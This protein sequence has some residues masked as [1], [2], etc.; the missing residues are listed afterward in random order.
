MKF[1]Q[2]LPGI[3]WSVQ[4]CRKNMHYVTLFMR[5]DAFAWLSTCPTFRDL[6]LGRGFIKA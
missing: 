1:I 4:T 5:P 3:G 6:A 2:Q